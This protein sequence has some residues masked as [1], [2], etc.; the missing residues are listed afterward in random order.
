MVISYGY[1]RFLFHNFGLMKGMS[2]MSWSMNML[3]LT[4]ITYLRIKCF[5]KSEI[6]NYLLVN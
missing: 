4:L 1:L 6:M 2:K 5:I 3:Q